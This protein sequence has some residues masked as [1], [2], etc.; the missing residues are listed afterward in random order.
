VNTNLEQVDVVV[1]V[2]TK[3]IYL[4]PLF[5]CRSGITHL[6]VQSLARSIESKGLQYPVLVQPK[7]DVPHIP[8]GFNYRLIVGFR[9]FYAC[10]NLLKLEYIPAI[11]KRGI[12]NEEARVL[13]LLENIDRKDLNILEEARA[14][15]EIYPNAATKIGVIAERFRRP[16]P[17]VVVR[18]MLLKLPE[19][20]Q[21]AAADGLINQGDIRLLHGISPTYTIRALDKML[22][23]SVAKKQ[24]RTPTKQQPTKEAIQTRLNTLINAGLMGL[25]AKLLLWAGG[26]GI[27]DNEIDKEIMESINDTLPNG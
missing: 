14:I 21:Q 24:R 11:V 18:L 3:E 25:P 22:D 7:E 20:V 26:L 16:R 8:D 10:T 9:R 5:N 17:W 15:A 6:S 13:N 27:S 12:T 4:E 23:K 1:K 2:P 19:K